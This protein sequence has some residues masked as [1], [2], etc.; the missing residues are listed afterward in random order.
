MNGQPLTILLVEDNVDHAE[1]V[2]RNLEEFQVAN[3]IHHVADGESALDYLRERNAYAD[4]TKY[5]RPDLILLDL[6]L[7]RIDG[8][9]VLKEIKDDPALQAIPVVIL[10]SSDAERDL[11]MAYKYHA[12]SYVTKPVDFGIFA[13]LLKD[14][15]YYWLAW[16]KRPW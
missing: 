16:N 13:R 9:E 6:R 5:H 1:M 8:L 10:T 11:A 7:P 2:I 12:N 15:G 4:R 3:Q 14:L